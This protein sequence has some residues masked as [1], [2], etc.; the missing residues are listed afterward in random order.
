MILCHAKNDIAAKQTATAAGSAM[1]ATAPWQEER[2]REEAGDEEREGD[3]AGGGAGA[4]ELRLDPEPER[5][6]D[7]VD[8]GVV[9]ELAVGQRSASAAATAAPT[10][11]AKTGRGRP[12]A[13]HTTSPTSHKG[14]R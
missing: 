4:R 11:D 7:R 12:A 9:R 6:R 8:P 5:A 13:S 14:T 1:R 2:R 3:A 10:R